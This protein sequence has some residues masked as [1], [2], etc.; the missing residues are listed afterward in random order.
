MIIA[1]TFGIAA[2]SFRYLEN[3]VMRWARGREAR[4]PENATLSPAAG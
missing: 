1:V 2:L 4:T 3:P